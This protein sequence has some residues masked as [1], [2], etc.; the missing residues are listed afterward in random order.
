MRDRRGVGGVGVAVLMPFYDRVC[1]RKG[2][3]FVSPDNPLM[4]E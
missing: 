4:V 2:V 1:S 3:T